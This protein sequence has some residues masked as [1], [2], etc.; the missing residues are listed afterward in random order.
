MASDPDWPVARQEFN[1]EGRNTGLF[2]FSVPVQ[3]LLAQMLAFV[4]ALLVFELSHRLFALSLN[5]LVLGLIQGVFAALISYW[6]RMRLW[7]LPIQFVLPSATLFFLALQISPTWYLF[8]FL[9][10]LMVFWGAIFSRVPLYLSGT[11]VWDEVLGLIPQKEGLKILDVGS[12]IGGPALYFAKKRPDMLVHGVEISP[13]LW[14][15]SCLRR[16]VT[17]SSARFFLR[18]YQNMHFG[19]YDVVFAYLS[20]V[21][22]DD[23]WVKAKKEMKRGSLFLSFEFVVEDV[24]PQIRMEIGKKILFGWRI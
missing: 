4:L 16:A 15:V 14:L 9:I 8:V 23:L 12:G 19:K 3:A 7:W 24:E 11:Q 22:M 1:N 6:R 10:L 13:F 2:A 20:P 5:I 21:V 18:N 17:R